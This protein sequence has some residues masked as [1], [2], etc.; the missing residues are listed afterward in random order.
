[1]Q[2]AR[3]KTAVIGSLAAALVIGLFQTSIARADGQEVVWARIAGINPN[4]IGGQDIGG[5]LNPVHPV[6]FPWSVTRGRAKLDLETNE[7]HFRVDGLSM[8]ASPSPFGGIG[9]TGV[10]TKVKGTI[11]CNPTPPNPVSPFPPID[12]DAV[13]LSAHGNASFHGTLSIPVAC[14]PQNLVF[15]LRVAE[16]P[17]FVFPSI[18]DLWLAHGAARRVR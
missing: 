1:M 5:I 3:G 4:P 2:P 11:V 17:P 15:L 6:G 14:A 16:T 13:E 10:V 7:V 18:V 9:T 12:T 8:G